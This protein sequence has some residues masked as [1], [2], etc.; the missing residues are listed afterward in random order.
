MV[1]RTRNR[2]WPTVLRARLVV[3]SRAAGLPEGQSATAS[4]VITATIQA[5][6]I[7]LGE[8]AGSSRKHA[9]YLPFWA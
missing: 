9:G 2:A 8:Q 7:K 1:F 6:L 3:K 4:Q 5:R